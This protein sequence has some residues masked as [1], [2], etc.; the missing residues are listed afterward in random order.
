MV[1]LPRRLLMFSLLKLGLDTPLVGVVAAPPLDGEEVVDWTVVLVLP[2]PRNL[3]LPLV[4]D[5]FSAWTEL[6]LSFCTASSSTGLWPG[7][8]LLKPPFELLLPKRARV[9]WVCSGGSVVVV[10]PP[11]LLD[12]NLESIKSDL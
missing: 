8:D 12:L 7:L 2:L 6:E 10:L 3:P 5:G 1:G 9:R 4:D 11:P